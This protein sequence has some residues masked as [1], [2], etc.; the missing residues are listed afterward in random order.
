MFTHVTL[1]SVKNSL[2]RAWLVPDVYVRSE[3]ELEFWNFDFY[4]GRE[5]GEPGEKP[6]WQGRESTNNSTHV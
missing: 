6:L 1:M 4:G 2:V 5:T 3:I